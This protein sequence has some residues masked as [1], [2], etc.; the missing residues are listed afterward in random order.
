MALAYFYTGNAKCIEL[1]REVTDY[2]L[3][4]LP[5]DDIP[6]WDLTFVDGDEPRDS[7]AAA[8]A[9]CGMLAMVPYL[10]KNEADKY[11]ADA[12]KLADALIAHC[13]VTDPAVSNGLLLHG[14]YAKNSPYNPIP[15]DRGVD[16]CN[17][18]GDYFYM[19]LLTRLTADWQMYW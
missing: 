8:I 7:S 11:R 3:S 16:E 15:K 10:E 12:E 13:A 9:A 2:F 5:E 1:F 14:V 19:E 4:R 18:W 17:T 6:Y